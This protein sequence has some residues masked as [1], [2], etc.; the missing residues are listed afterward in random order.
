MKQNTTLYI[1]Y[2]LCSLYHKITQN[3]KNNFSRI[4]FYIYVHKNR[5]YLLLVQNFIETNRWKQ[6]RFHPNYKFLFDI[7]ICLN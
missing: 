2:I 6:K 7:K 1:G 4:V 3:F 5:I